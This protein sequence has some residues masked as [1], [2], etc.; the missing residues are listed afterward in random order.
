V[1]TLT[2]PPLREHLEDLILLV[3]HYLDLFSRR[4]KKQKPVITREALSF[5]KNYQ[6]PG[7]IRELKNVIEHAVV[8][9]R[10]QQITP[11]DI[12]LP[13]EGQPLTKVEI[14]EPKSFHKSI[15]SH[16][17]YVIEDALKKSNGNQ[18]KAAQLLGLQRTYLAR[19]I[20]Q[21]NI[22]VED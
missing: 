21:L 15:E 3:D 14:G 10:D 19:L 12:I 20:R 2:V 22:S 18:S 1:I 8:M 7:N 5:L 6:W 4:C 11:D 13:E 9:G 16:K 17:R